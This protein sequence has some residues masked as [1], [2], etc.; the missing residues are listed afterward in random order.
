MG[1]CYNLKGAMSTWTI[2]CL[3][4]AGVWTCETLSSTCTDH[5]QHKSPAQVYFKNKQKNP[6]FQAVRL[7]GNKINKCNEYM[8]YIVAFRCVHESNHLT[9][10]KISSVFI[11]TTEIFKKNVNWLVFKALNKIPSLYL[12]NKCG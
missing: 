5:V 7:A 12:I 3:W 2:P 4:K 11:I 8:Y 9:S 6:S 10:K 1:I